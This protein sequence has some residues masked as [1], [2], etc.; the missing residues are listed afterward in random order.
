[1]G[2]K[3]ELLQRYAGG[4]RHVCPEICSKCSNKCCENG[5]CM[6]MPIDIEPFTVE[7][8]IQMI[9]SG[10]YVIEIKAYDYNA[11]L[12]DL[13]TREVD[14]D[15][16]FRIN[17]P[18]SACSLLTKKGCDLSE[19]ERPCLGLLLVPDKG[20]CCKQLVPKNERINSWKQQASIMEKVVQ[21]YAD[22]DSYSLAI[23]SFDEVAKKFYYK[24]MKNEL[25][26]KYDE[27]V[28][29]CYA[30][31]L[32]IDLFNKIMVIANSFGTSTKI[33]NN[34]V[35]LYFSKEYK[36]I[37]GRLVA[38]QI[39][40]IPY[41]TVTGRNLPE[42]KKQDFNAIIDALTKYNIEFCPLKRPTL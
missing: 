32:Q 29:C 18:H 24:L 27:S 16:V 20:L 12:A 13:S 2:K 25:F 38:V 21:H 8:I 4:T 19:K 37:S 34:L 28:T 40:C 30:R 3:E 23:E 10:K 7:H 42:S 9:D 14:D 39:M 35:E 31:W 5:G 11:V 6:L 17:K 15:G 1:M 26:E 22:K 36:R 33:I 41:Y